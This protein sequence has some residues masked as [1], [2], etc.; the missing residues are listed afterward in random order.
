[1]EL[2]PLIIDTKMHGYEG[3][4]AAFVVSGERTA[5]VETG[6]KSVVDNVLRELDGAGIEH[7]DWIVVTHIHLDHAGAAGTLAARFPKAKIAV[8]EVGAPH[9]IDP[10]K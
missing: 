4:T 3:I 9:L 2:Q 6:P 7:L 5:L 8:H 10:T 1:M